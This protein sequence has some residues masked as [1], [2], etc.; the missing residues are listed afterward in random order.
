VIRRLSLVLAALTA[1]LA[2]VLAIGVLRHPS[3]QVPAGAVETVTVDAAAAAARLAGAVRLR[4]IS[5]ETPS[6][7][8]A[9]E[10]LRL[11]AYLAESFPRTHALLKRETVGTFSLLYEWPGRDARLAPI[12][13]M[14]HQDVVPIAPGT[15]AQWHADPFGGELRDGYVWGRGTWDDKGNL[16]AILEAVEGLLAAGFV[17][18]RTVY[19]AF[20]HDEEN[21]GAAG[22]AAIAKLLAARG[23]HLAYVTD[24]GLLIGDG[25]VPGLAQ[26]AALIGLAEKGSATLR[27]TAREAPGHSSMPGARSAIGSLAAALATLERS[28]LPASLRGVPSAMLETLAP[29]MRWPQRIA[30]SNLW[31]TE[32]LVRGQLAARP[33]TDAMLRTTTALTVVSGGNK[34][35]VLPGEATALVNFR[36]LPG[37]TIERVVAH[38]R[39]AVHDDHI[40]VEV[41][42]RAVEASPVASREADGYRLIERTVRGLFPDVLVAP[43]LMIGGTDSRHFATLADNVYRFSPVR[44]RPEDL[45]RFHGTDERIAVANYVE[46]I[47]FYRE[48]LRSGTT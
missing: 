4:T 29:Q 7:D 17:P 32:P 10:L 42:P 13:L 39:A 37:D 23:V 20:G 3:R 18:Q 25:M 14:A 40:E 6:A 33:A 44:A 34:E 9:A 45:P 47:R 12:L 2:A 21:G 19:L 38:V 22:A 5:Y 26:P 11:H 16:M 46:L 48:L 27:L 43:G 8:S 31:L 41:Q 24:E 35:N 15:E 1:V 30:L 28:P 36:L